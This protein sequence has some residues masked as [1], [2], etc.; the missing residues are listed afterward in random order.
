MA[1][2]MA[3][4]VEESQIVALERRMQAVELRTRGKSYVEIARELGVPAKVAYS[5]VSGALADL[6]KACR[7]KTHE[8]R[9]LEVDRLDIIFRRLSDAV[10]PSVEDGEPVPIDAK[11]IETI[12][13]VMERRAKLLGLDAPTK[14]AGHDGGPLTMGHYVL[15]GPPKTDEEA[16][17]FLQG[18]LGDAF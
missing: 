13:K 12:L 14:I 16:R 10:F 11:L 2:A 3:D 6:R 9:E 1:N 7:E 18:S 8:L 4:P 5:I 17:R 15:D